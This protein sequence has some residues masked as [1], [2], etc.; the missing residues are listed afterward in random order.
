MVKSVKKPLREALMDI[1]RITEWLKSIFDVEACSHDDPWTIFSEI[2]SKKMFST[3]TQEIIHRIPLDV[4]N[5]QDFYKDLQYAFEFEE[6]L[7]KFGLSSSQTSD[8]LSQFRPLALQK[9]AADVLSTFRD[10]LS[11]DDSQTVLVSDSTE[12]GILNEKKIPVVDK[13]GVESF[14]NPLALEPCVVSIQS[15][16]FIEMIYQILQ[17]V[18]ESDPDG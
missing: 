4:E 12:R 2:Y 14:S 7:N 6:E 18:E 11:S 3:V 8:L 1:V 13:K 5:F 15:Q 17:G 9:K 16:T 10:V